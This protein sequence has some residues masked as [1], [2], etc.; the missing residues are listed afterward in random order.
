MQVYNV[1]AVARSENP[2]GGLVVMGGDNVPP[3]V[4]IGWIDRGAKA[5]PAPPPRL[6]R[7]CGVLHM[8]YTVVILWAGSLEAKGNSFQ[9]VCELR[10]YRKELKKFEFND[11]NRICL[12]IFRVI[13][14]NFPLIIPLGF[15]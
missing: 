2:G 7:A 6:R 10:Y 3:L 5:P 8:R 9:K 13:T 15:L 4:E 14:E 1:R 11:L 12:Y